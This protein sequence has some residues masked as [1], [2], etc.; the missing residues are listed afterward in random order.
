MQSIFS[1]ASPH[2]L[3]SG[4]TQFKLSRMPQSHTNFASPQS[5]SV[6]SPTSLHQNNNTF[7]Q[8]TMA[9]HHAPSSLI[10][11]PFYSATHLL[12]SL[13]L[14]PHAKKTTGIGANPTAHAPSTTVALSTPKLLYIPVAKSGIPAA[15]TLLRNVFAAT[16]LFACTP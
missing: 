8:H 2:S 10:L 12:L 14:S 13:I 6:P 15:N 5:A 16:A 4:T 1:H 3:N 7:E 11:T 9:T